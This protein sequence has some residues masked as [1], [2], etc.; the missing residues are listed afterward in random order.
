MKPIWFPL[1]PAIFALVVFGG[2]KLGMGQELRGIYL[3]L[4][5][6]LVVLVEWRLK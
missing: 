5:A 1:I 3:V 4:V 6:I 2:W